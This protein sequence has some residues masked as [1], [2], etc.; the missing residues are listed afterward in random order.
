[1]KS[2]GM[3]V[4]L[5]GCKFRISVSLA[6]LNRIGHVLNEQ[7]TGYEHIFFLVRIVNIDFFFYVLPG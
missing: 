6:V 4:S 7:G 3:P 5:W 1:M 2:T